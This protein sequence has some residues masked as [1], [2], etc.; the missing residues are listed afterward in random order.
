[1]RT[2][3]HRSAL[4]AF[5]FALFA[6]AAPAWGDGT[7]ATTLPILSPADHVAI[8][9]YD[10]VSYFTDGKPVKGSAA[11]SLPF[12]D[13]TWQFADPSHKAMFA[14]DPDRYMPQYG[15][16][17]AGGM[18]L[19]VS[20]PANPDNWVIVDDKLYMIAGTKADL[21]AWKKNAIENIKQADAHWKQMLSQ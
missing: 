6:A 17:C 21:E 9:G 7:T 2:V 10:T 4:L 8:Q 5:A 13:S 3:M 16:S 1:M 11:I 19:G 20:V 14:A 15:G 12:D 18:A